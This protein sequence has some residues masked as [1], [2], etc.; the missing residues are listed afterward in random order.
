[1]RGGKVSV[2][3]PPLHQTVLVAAAGVDV[4]TF[5]GGNPVIDMG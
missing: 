5:P 2:D 1:M 3:E 4:P